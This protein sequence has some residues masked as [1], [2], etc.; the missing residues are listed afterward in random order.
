MARPHNSLFKNRSHAE[1]WHSESGTVHTAGAVSFGDPVLSRG[2]DLQESRIILAGH[3]F[4]PGS[5]ACTALVRRCILCKS[6]PLFASLKTTI[7]YSASSMIFLP[8]VASKPPSLQAR[9][10]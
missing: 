4:V 6:N 8:T 7:R 5:V 3:V 9:K 10:P 1:C 2:N